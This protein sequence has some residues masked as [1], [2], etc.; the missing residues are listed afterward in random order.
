MSKITDQQKVDVCV[1]QAV[2]FFRQGN[3]KAWI[4]GLWAS[5]I[6]GKYYDYATRRMA[7]EL[8]VEPDTIEDYAHAYSIFEELGKANRGVYREVVFW[9]RRS[10]YIYYSH[11]RVLWEARE[12]YGLT[13]EQ[14]FGYLMDV[15]Q[16]EGGLSSRKLEKMLKGK[17]AGELGWEWYSQQSLKSLNNTLA[18][19]DLPDAVRESLVPAYEVLGAPPEEPADYDPLIKAHERALESLKATKEETIVAR[20]FGDTCGNCHAP[21]PCNCSAPHCVCGICGDL[22]LQCKCT[23]RHSKGVM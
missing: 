4:T 3:E 11:F 23:E 1:E 21:W 19:P 16:A 10:K 5:R 6:V 22:V 9:A 18:C 12:R 15:I 14:V 13:I 20:R 7:D 17:H 8:E 2:K